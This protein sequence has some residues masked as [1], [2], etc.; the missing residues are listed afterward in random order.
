MTIRFPQSLQEMIDW[1][2]WLA[3]QVVAIGFAVIFVGIILRH[4]SFGFWAIPV[5]EAQV[6]AYYAGAWWLYRKARA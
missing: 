5:Q 2:L 6:L 4:W 1:L 3:D